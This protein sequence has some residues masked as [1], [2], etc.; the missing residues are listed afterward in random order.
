MWKVGLVVGMGWLLLITVVSGVDRVRRT[1]ELNTSFVRAVMPLE[2]DKF[3]V[4]ASSAREWLRLNL[5]RPPFPLP[6][7][8]TMRKLHN[9]EER[10]YSE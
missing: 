7:V 3:V 10:K 2:A 5:P 6:L 1:R 9:S 8:S 4:L